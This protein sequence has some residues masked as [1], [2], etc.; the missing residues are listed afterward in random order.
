M[1]VMINFDEATRENTQ[2]HNAHSP[3]ILNIQTDTNSWRL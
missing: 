2:E 1:N 3:Q